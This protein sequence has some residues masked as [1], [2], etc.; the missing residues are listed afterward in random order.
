MKQFA[1]TNMLGLAKSGSTSS[2]C[3]LEST[4]PVNVKSNPNNLNMQGTINKESVGTERNLMHTERVGGKGDFKNPYVDS[5]RTQMNPSPSVPTFKKDGD[6]R[7]YTPRDKDPK[8][9]TQR[10]STQTNK[11]VKSTSHSV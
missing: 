3:R 5:Q 1:G 2:N 11:Q 9:D 6:K 10:P 7:P 8:A 4:A